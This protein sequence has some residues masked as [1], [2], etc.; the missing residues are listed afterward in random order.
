M[1]SKQQQIEMPKQTP[2]E[3]VNNFMEV[4]QG[5]TSE[6]AIKE[7]ERCLNCK[8]PQCRK[9]CPVD[10]DI[11]GFIQ[12]IR[13]GYSVFFILGLVF[14]TLGIT[15][16]SEWKKNHVPFSKLPS[17]QQKLAIVTMVVLGVLVFVGLAAYMFFSN[18]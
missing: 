8:N 11:S 15:H 12:M 14:F 9:G 4:A 10:I 18:L 16:K 3:R 2:G 7:A 5:Y 13:E 1:S 17:K 6:L